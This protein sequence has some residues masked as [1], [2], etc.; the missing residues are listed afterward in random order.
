MK[1]HRTYLLAGSLALAGTGA[2]AEPPSVVTSIKPV[3]TLVAGVMQGVGTP[4]LIIEGAGSPH[5]YSL[6]PSNARALQNADVIFWIGPGMEAF[7]DRPIDSLGEDA[8]VITLMDA[9]GLR[10][11]SFREGGPFEGHAHDDHGDNDHAEHGHDDD[12]E[13]DEHAEHGHDDDH[14]KDEHAGHGHDD[15]HEKDE[16]AGHDDHAGDAR[17][18]HIWLDPENAKAM[19]HEIA[20]ALAE[21]DPANA[22]R[23]EANAET[24]ETRI[25]G[26]AAELRQTLAPVRERPFIVFHDA[27][28][29]FERRF[30]LN[31]AGSITVSPEVIPGAERVS[32]IRNKVEEL[33]ATCVFSEPQ[34][35]PRLVN[36]VTEGTAA[37]PGVL[38]PLGAG[39]PNGPDLY[40]TLMRNMAVSMRAC[41]SPTG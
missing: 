11:A 31:A 32:D 27:Y 38:D 8:R 36:V 29:H 1:L 12:H 37:K 15:D 4:T 14:E 20:E 23:Y 35:T 30:D 17:D 26:L 9:H 6:R 39:I 18:A 33:G 22:A 34:F 7:L 41:L 25:D 13:K 21:A 3:H 5:T 28:Q 10:H 40:F 16:H 24:L 19:T 2:N